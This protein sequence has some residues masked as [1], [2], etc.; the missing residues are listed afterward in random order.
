MRLNREGI[1]EL[2]KEEK[3]KEFEGKTALITGAAYGFGFEL[4]KQAAMRKMNIVAVDIMGDALKACE[5]VARE[6]GAKDIVLVEADVSLYE[7]TK[8]AVDITMEKFGQID[9][10]VNNAGTAVPGPITDIPIEDWEWV[11]QTNFMSHIYFMKQVIPIM[12]AQGTHCHI[13]NVASIAGLIT[14]RG[15]PTYYTTKHA[16]AALSECVQYEVQ[17][18]GFDIQVH[19]FCPGY[20]QTNFHNV[21]DYRPERFKS[22]LEDPYYQSEV[23]KVETERAQN[24]VKSGVPIDGFGEIVFKAIEDDQF[25]ILTHAPYNQ[26]IMLQSK[27]RVDGVN[28]DIN[29][30]K[31]LRS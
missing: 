18:K 12:A 4:V 2:T 23:C 21:G 5:P 3:M 28:P 1:D 17:E 29:F 27:N 6:L 16:A 20:V 9:L 15:L 24:D 31:S 22:A 7:D 11:V 30:L 8:K 10:L 14:F 25:Y 26:L 13:L 19:L